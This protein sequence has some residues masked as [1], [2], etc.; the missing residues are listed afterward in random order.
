MFDLQNNCCKSRSGYEIIKSHEIDKQWKEQH[1]IIMFILSTGNAVNCRGG[2]GG[3][4]MGNYMYM[5]LVHHIST[6]HSISFFFILLLVD[7][8]YIFHLLIL[9]LTIL[10]N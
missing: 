9:I 1:T 10:K 8:K 4:I 5:Y 6:Q 7:F 2:G 3:L